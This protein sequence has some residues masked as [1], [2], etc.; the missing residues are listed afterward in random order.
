MEALQ[1]VQVKVHEEPLGSQLALRRNGIARRRKWR[2]FSPISAGS[3]TE[4]CSIVGRIDR[5]CGL[6]RTAS[7]L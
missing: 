5:R 2:A 3:S 4:A 1:R 6:A 7:M